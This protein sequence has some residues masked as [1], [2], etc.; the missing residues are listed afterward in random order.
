MARVVKRGTRRRP[1]QSALF[2]FVVLAAGLSV[3]RA[4][5][6]VADDGERVQRAF[7][8]AG[9]TV[10]FAGARFL[11]NDDAFQLALPATPAEC[12]RV[13][14]VGPRGMSLRA[15]FV[16]A[17]FEER[18]GRST[19]HAGALQLTRCGAPASRIVVTNESGSGAVEV[20]VA[21]SRT[22]PPSLGA[23]LPDRGQIDARPPELPL[24]MSLAAPE[25]RI[26]L[27]N[28]ALTREGAVDV[29]SRSAIAPRAGGQVS[30][31]LEPGCHRLVVVAKDLGA[32]DPARVDVDAEARDEGGSL[33]A[34]DKTDAP[35]AVLEPCTTER[36]TVVVAYAGV[37]EGATVVVTSGRFP[38]ASGLPTVFGDDARLRM[39]R[40]LRR[41]HV[42]PAGEPVALAQGGAGV[43][44]VPFET[45]SRACYL[46]V[47][48]M[49]EGAPRGLG[50]RVRGPAIDGE[51]ERASDD[52]GVVAFCA[53]GAKRVSI[54]VEARSSGGRFG[55]VVYR[56]SER[57][58]GGRR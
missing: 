50:I 37:P 28:E 54:D 36:K 26:V 18:E 2:A 33:L 27:A 31:E 47:A 14:L 55:L 42:V 58:G 9:A 23:I 13:A 57:D 19:S 4:R 34:R 5:A 51:D 45:E 17:T 1:S 22:P 10:S 11:F 32:A 56:A 21:H 7:T 24:P 53:R 8:S 30:L 48:A 49:A 39:D 38:V 44:R 41:R 12:V 3:N 52:S 6:D 16:D 35:D 29:T 46:V 15:R 40:A 25:R 43:A 20:I